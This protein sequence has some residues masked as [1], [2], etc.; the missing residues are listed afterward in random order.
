M[1]LLDTS[2]A[3]QRDMQHADQ[4]DTQNTP[5]PPWHACPSRPPPP[6]HPPP[7]SALPPPHTRIPAGTRALLLPPC[8]FSSAPRLHG[9]TE[10]APGGVEVAHASARAVVELAEQLREDE[11]VD[12]FCR[13]SFAR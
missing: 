8:C 10:S 13:L 3:D 7:P 2:G 4:R 12:H 5:A 11:L 6:L 9:G 1:A